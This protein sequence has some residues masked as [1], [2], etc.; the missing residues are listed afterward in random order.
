M[1]AQKSRQPKSSKIIGSISKGAGVLVGTAVVTGKR[2]IGTVISPRADKLQAPAEGKKK[3][4]G[5]PV[6]KGPKKKKKAVKRKAT[7]P[8]AK[9]PASKKKSTRVSAKS[10][11][12]VTSK[13]K[14]AGTKIKKTVKSEGLSP[15]R[16]AHVSGTGAGTN[17]P[18]GEQKPQLR[19]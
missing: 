14:T 16:K 15:S 5:K 8:S 12:S 13:K 6:S 7:S 3:V 2:I 4:T 1:V 17:V 9:S 10:K 19:N 18:V 11:Q